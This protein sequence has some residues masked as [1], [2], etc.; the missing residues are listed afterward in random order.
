MESR[1]RQILDNI[2][3]QYDVSFFAFGS[4]VTQ[5]FKKFSDVDLCFFESL[6]NSALLQLEDV[7]EESDLPY[8]VDLVDFHKCDGTFQNII[9]RNAVCIQAS[10]KLQ[11][12][13]SNH[14]K[15]FE[16]FPTV[17]GF[18]VF[19]QNKIHVVNCGLQSSMFNIV[20]G[21]LDDTAEKWDHGVLKIIE[22]FKGQPFAWWI[23]PSLGNHQ[24]SKCL[25]SHG[26]FREAEEHAMICDLSQLNLDHGQSDLTINLA[27]NHKT[28]R[29]FV[30]LLVPYDP[31]A[32]AF[33]TKVQ[34]NQ[35][36]NVKEKFFVGYAHEKAVS[37][38]IL[39]QENQSA[40]IFGLVTSESERGKGYGT[41]MMKY[42][43]KTSKENG[44][45]WVTLSASSNSARRI[46]ERMGFGKIG[47]FQCFE[48]R[49]T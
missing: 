36:K 15:H 1:H 43:L 33:Y 8:K 44:A 49:A 18:D 38:A 5:N 45:K 12:L 32:E 40:A 27:T 22:L 25:E 6:S 2:I 9:L 31:A 29:D 16:Y 47:A 17:L 35:L 23:P 39:C 20:Y 30:S 41:S 14:L 3:K 46:Y 7:F 13:E 24:F 42:L 4:R 10:S 48:Y 11:I 19:Q 34:E 26:F 28:L 37:V 21:A